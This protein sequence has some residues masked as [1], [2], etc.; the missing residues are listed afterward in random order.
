MQVPYGN[1][2]W[3][4]Y[5]PTRRPRA[6]KVNL[7]TKD[8]GGALRKASQYVTLRATGALDP[9]TDHAPQD[10]VTIAEAADQ[11]A[12]EKRQSG[13]SPS[14]V[15]TD[16][17]H[18]RRFEV[19][20]HPGFLI[21]H[22]ERRHIVAFLNKP[23]QAGRTPSASYR[24]R[25]R[26][27]L[28]HFFEWSVRRG[29]I[30][31]NP[32]AETAPPKA[33]HER[34]EHITDAE[35]KAIIEAIEASETSTGKD[36]TWLK[37]WIN[38]GF[39]TGLRP[40]EQRHLTWGAASLAERHVHVGKGHRTKTAKS[41]R[42]VP[43]R[44]EALAILKRRSESREGPK[45]AH[46]FTGKGGGPVESRY[47]T[48]QIQ[49]FAEAAKIEKNVVAYSLRHGYGTR[50]AQAGVPLWE[51]ANLM[52]TSV[53]MIERHYGHYDPARGAAHVDRVFGESE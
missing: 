26:A 15:K 12:K 27:S 38:F 39:M 41:A 22:V 19:S 5:D 2:K 3:V 37:D 23:T 42:T 31:T 16:E 24:Q 1:W 49:S 53:K 17:G 8:Q 47:V 10:G 30:R 4:V 43:V 51:L 40:G 46:V 9:W 28:H 35:R 20:L 36:R 11:Y 13:K 52:G 34:R 32:V 33:S 48:K 6:K 44:G 14:T 25:I 7:R 21:Q 50:M 45:E 29:L 18:L